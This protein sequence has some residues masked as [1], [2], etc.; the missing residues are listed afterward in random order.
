MS[1]PTIKQGLA[2]KNVISHN[3]RVVDSPYWLRK[4][5]Q[6]ANSDC[7]DMADMP[8]NQYPSPP[9]ARSWGR[10]SPSSPRP[11]DARG[12]RTTAGRFNQSPPQWSSSQAPQARQFA[13]GREE[14]NDENSAGGRGNGHAY[15][16]GDDE[17]LGG[18]DDSDV[19][20][21]IGDEDEDDV[22]YYSI[23]NV[24]PK[25]GNPALHVCAWS[26][27]KPKNDPCR[28]LQ[29][30]FARPTTPSRGGCTQTNSR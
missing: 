27:T 1:R 24:S 26:K 30:K 9:S 10:G 7:R 11:E 17:E 20:V 23:L 28:P 16:H 14:S 2:P 13:T 8:S 5:L 4:H 18:P 6:R 12:A 19:D 25:V 29:V 21:D 15:G 3:S 22:D